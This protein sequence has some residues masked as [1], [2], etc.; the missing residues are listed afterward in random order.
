MGLLDDIETKIQ[1]KSGGVREI[2]SQEIRLDLHEQPESFDPEWMVKHLDMD[3]VRFAL[4]EHMEAHVANHPVV[5][6]IERRRGALTEARKKQ[7]ISKL[8]SERVD[9]LLR[10]PED[11]YVALEG[12]LDRFI[13]VESATDDAIESGQWKQIPGLATR[14]ASV[15]DKLRSTWDDHDENHV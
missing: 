3:R 12:E 13:N 14:L 4:Q 6:S 7:L 9:R 8:A 11:L 1:E 2:L 10:N 15:L 5:R